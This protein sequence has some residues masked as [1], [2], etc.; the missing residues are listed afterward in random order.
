MNPADAEEKPYSIAQVA[1]TTPAGSRVDFGA[2]EQCKASDAELEARGAAACPEAARTGGGTIV[3]DT[4]S[5]GGFPR[6]VENR[7][8]TFNNEGEVIG[9]ADST[10]IPPVPGFSRVVSRSP[11]E[12]TT[13]TISFP[14][15]PGSA[16]PDPYTAIKTM[17]LEGRPLASGGRA[18]A[19]TPPTCPASG[20]WTARFRFEYR[21]G[22]VQEAESALPCEELAAADRRAPRIRLRGVPRRRCVR[23]GFRVRARVS[24]TS[25]VRRVAVYLDGRLLRARGRPFVRARVAGARLAPGRHRVSVRARDRAGNRAR[26]SRRFRR[27]GSP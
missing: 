14:A 22:V 6:T 7:L 18:Y 9:V 2:I 10:Q 26:K 27:C 12:G 1:I 4:G 3:S 21:D 20:R 24:D 8:D 13:T 19:R 17:H 25:G 5:D 23:G 11:V 15:F 16:P